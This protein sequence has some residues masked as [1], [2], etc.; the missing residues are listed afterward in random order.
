MAKVPVG[1]GPSNPQVVVLVGATG[2]LSRRKLLPGLFHLVSSGFI[3]DCRIVGASWTA[4][5][6]R[7]D[8]SLAMRGGEVVNPSGAGVVVV[9]PSLPVRNL[10]D[11][12]KLLS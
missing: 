6:S 11:L 9:H 8:G 4:V 1:V 7:L 5:L 10:T 12:V 3:P 2:D